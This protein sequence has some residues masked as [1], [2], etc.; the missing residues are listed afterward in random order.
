MRSSLRAILMV[1]GIFLVSY[2]IN[3]VITY[4]LDAYKEREVN[5]TNNN[6]TVKIVE[7]RLSCLAMNVYR[8]AAGEPFEGKVAVAQVIINRINDARFPNDICGVIYQK[9]IFMEKI[10]CQFT[11]HCHGSSKARPI[12]TVAYDESF[13]VA[14]KV[15]LENFRLDSV[16]NAIYYHADNVH[17]NWKYQKVAKIGSH[18]F[19]KD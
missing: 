8:E 11:W 16:K 5:K 9:N 3:K 7:Q 4:R 6:P 15:L 1:L 2:G 18:I 10:V 13:Q 19:Y 14:K 12:D 17:P